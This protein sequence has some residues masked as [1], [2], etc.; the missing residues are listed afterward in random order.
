[1]KRMYRARNVDFD[2]EMT[3]TTS[4]MTIK[5]IAS[6]RMVRGLSIGKSPGRKGLGDGSSAGDDSP[7]YT[8]EEM[9]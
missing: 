4:S 3:P 2:R 9:Y 7:I 5:A 8:G 6:P 1:M